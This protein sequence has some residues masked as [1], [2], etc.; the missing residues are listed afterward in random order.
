MFADEWSCFTA[1]ALLPVWQQG[2][3]FRVQFLPKG[4]VD[5]FAGWIWMNYQ[6]D[7]GRKSKWHDFFVFGPSVVWTYEFILMLQMRN[8]QKG[9]WRILHVS[10]LLS[11]KWLQTIESHIVNYKNDT[12][13]L[14]HLCLCPNSWAKNL[15]AE[16]PEKALEFSAL[17]HWLKLFLLF[18]RLASPKVIRK[19]IAKRY[20]SCSEMLIKPSC[21]IRLPSY[22]RPSVKNIPSWVRMGDLYYAFTR[23]FLHVSSP[24]GVPGVKDAFALAWA[25]PL[26]ASCGVSVL[27]PHQLISRWSVFFE[28]PK[29]H[30]KKASPKNCQLNWF[31]I[32]CLKYP[33]NKGNSPF[34]MTKIPNECMNMIFSWIRWF[35]FNILG[36]LWEKPPKRVKQQDLQCK[37]HQRI[38][39]MAALPFFRFECLFPF[40]GNLR[41]GK[42]TIWENKDSKLENGQWRHMKP[43]F[44]F[45]MIYS[46]PC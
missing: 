35:F 11:W 23:R 36:S 13:K 40:K 37:T 5:R 43:Y 32:T 9:W 10:A 29:N 6:N 14:V 44:L 26:G 46:Q 21:P 31:K 25:P 24:I 8:L 38:P 16:H 1:G 42:K 45:Q 33:S 12:L 28:H 7:K 19:A 4:K 18:Q 15:G 20:P 30:P 39:N 3:G 2:P 41:D 17:S 34:A 27:L 22:I